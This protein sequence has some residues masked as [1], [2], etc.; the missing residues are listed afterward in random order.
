MKLLLENW[1]RFLKEERGFGEGEPPNKE[2]WYKKQ[3]IVVEE[4]KQKINI[5]LD[6]DGVLVDFPSSMREY[7]KNVYTEAP[8]EVHPTS[9]S[10]RAVFRKLQNMNLSPEEV[11]ELYDRS[12]YK[13][14]SG[15]GYE[16]D[17]K[18]MSNYVFKALLGN[19]ELWLGMNK[20]EG[21][22]ALVDRAFE[23]ADEVFVLTAQVDKT[24]E[25][26]KKEWIATH[27]PQIE[28]TN[29]NVSRD[30]GARLRKL[31][32]L[33]AVGEDDLNILIDDR[34]PFLE[35]FIEA[36][37]AGIQYNFESPGSAFTELEALTTQ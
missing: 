14:Q 35:S 13:F 22:D 19:K 25:E 34:K 28:A 23:I 30:K 26:A 12:E 1:H 29:V 21:A 5:F 27:F 6:M 36:G 17:E 4:E 2:G 32:S 16:P 20:L 7:I 18:I 3:T 15:E 11:E 37:G 10:S 24:S 9:K 33:G 31:I 8:E